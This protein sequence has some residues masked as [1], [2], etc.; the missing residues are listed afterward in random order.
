MLRKKFIYFLPAIV[1]ILAFAGCEKASNDDSVQSYSS[2]TKSSQTDLQKFEYSNED[3]TLE[4]ITKIVD[5]ALQNQMFRSS[6]KAN[7]MKM[8]DGDYDVF[9]DFNEHAQRGVEM[10]LISA[11]D[12]YNEQVSDLDNKIEIV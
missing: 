9:I 2:I 5:I 1:L 7:A 11:A 12:I 6:L 3:Q 8:L 10:G 4:K